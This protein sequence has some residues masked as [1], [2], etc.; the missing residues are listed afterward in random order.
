LRTQPAQISPI[1]LFSIYSPYF[2]YPLTHSPLT[3]IPSPAHFPHPPIADKVEN[4]EVR[5]ALF[6]HYLLKA[7]DDGRKPMVKECFQQAWE[8]VRRSANLLGSTQ[9]P[10]R[11]GDSNVDVIL[12]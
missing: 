2:S 12:R 11:F 9:E 8:R 1:F 4:D 3:P 6:T 10:Q 5:G 7:L